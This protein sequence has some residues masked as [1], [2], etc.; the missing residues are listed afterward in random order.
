MLCSHPNIYN[1]GL[2]CCMTFVTFT[3]HSPFM[4]LCPLP[5][6][7]TTSLSPLFYSPNHHPLQPLPC[8]PLSCLT[9]HALVIFY[10]IS[11]GYILAVAI[12]VDL[13]SGGSIPMWLLLYIC[14]ARLRGRSPSMWRSQGGRL[15]GS[16]TPF[17]TQ[18]RRY[19]WYFPKIKL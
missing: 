3:F 2:I 7:P 17:L 6:C 19:T 10:G 9:P 16:S 14:C 11:I 1:V 18:K 15:G 4:S 12:G 5:L 13:D 8:K